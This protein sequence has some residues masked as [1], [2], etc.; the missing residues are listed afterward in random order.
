MDVTSPQVRSRASSLDSVNLRDTSVVIAA[1]AETASAETEL[2]VVCKTAEGAP[3]FLGM[4]FAAEHCVYSRLLP[5]VE[6]LDAVRDPLP[7]PRSVRRR[8]AHCASFGR[9]QRACGGQG[10]PPVARGC[11][12]ARRLPIL[13]ALSL[14]GTATHH[15]S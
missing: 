4:A 6:A 10:R 9:T 1:Q 15:D 3:G 12:L 2:R 14:P 5:A 8:G 11:V 13:R 7:W